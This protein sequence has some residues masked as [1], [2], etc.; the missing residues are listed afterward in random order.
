MIDTDREI[1]EVI[2]T[3]S[4]TVYRLAYSMVK[5]KADADDI[6]QEVFLRYI[7]SNKNWK[8]ENHRKAWFIRVTINC[9][10]KLYSSA[11]SRKTTVLSEAALQDNGYYDN[12]DE[13]LDVINSLPFRYKTVIHLF[14]YEDLPIEEIAR[15]TKQKQST[16][17]TQLTRARKLLKERLSEDESI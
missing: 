6:Y 7:K 3:Y 13:L 16:V 2:S 17:R 1:D 8:D 4:D 14:Y 9:C 15:L 10:K 12:H 11:W 5:N